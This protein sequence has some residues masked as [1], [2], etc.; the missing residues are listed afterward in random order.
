METKIVKLKDLKKNPNNPRVIRDDKYKKLVKSIQEFPQMLSIRPIVV[1]SD[2]VVLGGNMR[3]KAA[4]DAG[5]K[6]IPTIIADELSIEQQNEFIIKDNSS[7]GDWDW[8]LLANEWDNAKLIEWGIDIPN[9]E[10]DHELQG[11]GRQ[12]ASL[13]EKLDTYLNATIKQIVLYYEVEEYEY[14]LKNLDL[15]AESNNLPDNS[16]VL[17]FLIEQYESQ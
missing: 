1:N 8:D 15:I 16:S 11:K 10:V 4:K 7:F 17:K 5:L 14:V 13:E 12:L 9:F 6:E 3:L 2:M